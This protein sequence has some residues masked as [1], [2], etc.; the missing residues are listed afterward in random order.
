MDW[1]NALQAALFVAVLVAGAFIGLQQGTIRT[2]RGTVTD[3]R[4]RRD[5]LEKDRDE[6]SRDLETERKQNAAKIADMEGAVRV[7][8]DTVTAKEAIDS[9]STRLDQHHVESMEV[10]QAIAQSLAQGGRGT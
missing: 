4:G 1:L 3:L 10:L 8:T 9:L 7:L 6:L 2:L 5:D